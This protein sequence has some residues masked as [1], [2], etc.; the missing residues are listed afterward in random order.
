MVYKWT[1]FQY[2]HLFIHF[3]C[4]SFVQ[5]AF[6]LL[7]EA[8]SLSITFSYLLEPFIHCFLLAAWLSCKLLLT[9]SQSQHMVFRC[10]SWLMEICFLKSNT[11]FYF[12]KLAW[13]TLQSYITPWHS[14]LGITKS[15][16]YRR[17]FVTVGDW[18]ESQIVW[19]NFSSL[20]SKHFC[21]PSAIIFTPEQGTWPSVCPVR[22]LCGW[23]QR[24]GIVLGIYQRECVEAHGL[25]QGDGWQTAWSSA[26]SPWI[27]TVRSKK[28]SEG[29]AAAAAYL[30]LSVSPLLLSAPSVFAL[31]LVELVCFCSHSAG[32]TAASRC[33]FS[34]FGMLQCSDK[35]LNPYRALLSF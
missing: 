24:P 35:I 34:A 14:W 18:C 17:K 29:K 25:K 7:A 9:H 4:Q 33:L 12:V 8:G 32:H 30:C 26:D 20:G 27:I 19:R 10:Y 31:S 23:Q 5:F 11:N 13:A 22:L 2:T 3:N 6:V 16:D 15:R 1:L 21:L 28:E